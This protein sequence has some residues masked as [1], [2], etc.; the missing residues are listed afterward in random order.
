MKLNGSKELALKMQSIFDDTNESTTSIADMIPESIQINEGTRSQVGV[1]GRNGK[2]VSAYVHFDGYPRNMKPGLKKHMKNEKDV[3]T[4]IKKGGA[5]GIFDDKEIEY[6]NTSQKPLKGDFK[7][8]K[9]YINDAG[10]EGGAEYVYLYNMKDKKWYFA[11]VYGKKE[12]KKL[13]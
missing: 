6:Y 5:R 4:L 2:I 13:F 3:L 9:S 8:I 12:L 10:V 7:D 1:I 11:D